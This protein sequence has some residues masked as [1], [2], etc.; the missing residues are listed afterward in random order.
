VSGDPVKK[1]RDKIGRLTEGSGTENVEDIAQELKAIMMGKCGVFRDKKRL[2]EAQEK[3]SELQSRFENARVMDKS[4]RFNTD[5][6]WALE[7]S[8]LLTFSETVVAGA[9][10]RTESRGAHYRT[11]FPERDDKN[12]LKHTLAHKG[13]PGELPKLIYKSVNIDWDKYPPQERKY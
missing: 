8:H 11:D 10:T 3:V 2:S 13:A 6:L 1:N 7:T 9:L 4:K 5:V 12:W